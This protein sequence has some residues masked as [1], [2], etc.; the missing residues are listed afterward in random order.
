MYAVQESRSH[1]RCSVASL[2]TDSLPFNAE[3]EVGGAEM[4]GMGFSAAGAG[5]VVVA[6]AD[7]VVVVVVVGVGVAAEVV[8]DAEFAVSVERELAVRVC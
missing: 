6:C 4:S 2:S 8:V 1:G 5:D 3:D 7:A